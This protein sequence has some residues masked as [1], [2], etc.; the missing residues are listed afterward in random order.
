MFISNSSHAASY[1]QTHLKIS[2]QRSRIIYNAIQL[3][4]P[5]FSPQ[6][7]HSN[8]RIAPE[9]IVVCMLANLTKQKDHTTLLHAWKLVHSEL[10]TKGL[11]HVLLLA[12]RFGPTTQKVKALACDLALEGNVLFL[13]QVN[14]VS[15]LL[16][17]V[18]LGVLSSFSEGCPNGVLECMAAGIPVVGTDLP[19]IREALGAKGFSYLSLKGDASS[20]AQ[21]II[22]LSLDREKREELGRD[23][24]ERIAKHFSPEIIYSQ[25]LN[26]ISHV[27]RG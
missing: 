6:E 5:Q 4:Q 19:G 2:T 23:N 13:S 3:Q 17:I 12:G 15:G 27:M 7:W 24:M 1:I 8:L 20:L 22:D 11:P 10:A 9:S 21:K 16:S 26:A 18:D 14:D 25:F